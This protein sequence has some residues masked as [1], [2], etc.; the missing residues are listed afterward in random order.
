MFSN[1]LHPKTPLPLRWFTHRNIQWPCWDQVFFFPL[2]MWKNSTPNGAPRQ[3]R[4]IFVIYFLYVYPDPWEDD[5]IWGPQTISFYWNTPD[6]SKNKH[7]QKSGVGS[8]W[9]QN[10]DF[11]MIM[12]P[13]RLWASKLVNFSRL[14]ARLHEVCGSANA[15]QSSAAPVY[16]WWEWLIS[17]LLLV[18]I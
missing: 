1:R 18:D 9:Y 13:I 15:M 2:V 6:L 17:S 14:L 3:N 8:L 4:D 12:N 7:E 11:E 5:L 10:F 16:H